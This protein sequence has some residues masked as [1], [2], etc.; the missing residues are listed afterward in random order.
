VHACSELQASQTWLHV[1]QTPV[2]STATIHGDYKP[3]VATSDLWVLPAPSLL[4]VCVT[5]AILSKLCCMNW[6]IALDASLIESE[7]ELCNDFFF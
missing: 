4:V 7:G 1:A 5:D 6:P 2:A 3:V